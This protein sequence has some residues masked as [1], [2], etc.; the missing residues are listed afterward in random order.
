M[1]E[2][3]LPPLPPET[4]DELLSAALDGELDDAAAELGI[5]PET[6]RA[7]V[8]AHGERQGR[9]AAARDAVADVAPLDEVARRRLV[10]AATAAAGGSR[11]DARAHRRPRRLALGGVAAA[12]LAAL[13]LGVGS[14]TVIGI[15][16]WRSSDRADDAAGGGDADD[17]GGAVS[18]EAADSAPPPDL[19]EVSD[20]A[21]LR[22]GVTSQLAPGEDGD[23][24]ARFE[25]L[26]EADDGADSTTTDPASQAT[27]APAPTGAAPRDAREDD[28]LR[29]SDEETA[30]TKGAADP[31]L[32]A[33]A[34]RVA[35]ELQ[36]G[37]TPLLVATAT[38]GGRVAGVSV[39][40]ADDRTLV[41]VY[42][43]DDCT[44][45]T[46]QSWRSG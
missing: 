32:P 41:V 22:E 17:A 23:G 5:D 13:L 26:A 27:G 31:S 43:L 1:N 42:A 2:P 40:A 9:L 3:I 25:M 29:Q 19:G 37:D 8:A 7:T 20:P 24:S 45:L 36:R 44:L 18:P 39:F 10:S 28:R 35:E 33:C 6:A 30:A 34:A 38:Y 15:T 4:V 12:V 11:R 46:S 14:L 16:S 21:A